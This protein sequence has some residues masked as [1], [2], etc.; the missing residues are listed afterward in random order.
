M[1]EICASLLGPWDKHA[2]PT[3]PTPHTH[4]ATQQGAF[5]I[6]LSISISISSQ[7]LFLKLANFLHIATLLCIILH[8]VAVSF[9]LQR[10]L[11]CF[12]TIFLSMYPINGM[13]AVCILPCHRHTYYFMQR[14]TLKVNHCLF[15]TAVIE[16]VCS[17]NY[18]WARLHSVI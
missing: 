12:N 8:A 14:L 7:Q 1:S 3:P 17:A 16:E 9:Q 5:V 15:R 6:W 4:T 18:E 11:I 10:F 13:F 2:A